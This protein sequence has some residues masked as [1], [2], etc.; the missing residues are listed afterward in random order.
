MNDY[1]TKYLK[2]ITKETLNFMDSTI[3]V[4]RPKSLFSNLFLSIHGR[5]LIEEV[6]YPI[7]EQLENDV[8][9]S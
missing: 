4:D 1:A 6:I 5:L 7:K 9:A 3:A 2:L 8:F